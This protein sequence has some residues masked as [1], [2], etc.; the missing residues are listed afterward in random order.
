MN[1]LG[2]RIRQLRKEKGITQE[3][4]GKLFNL[5]KSTISQYESGKSNPDYDTLVKI[6]K[7]FNCS[8][9]YLLG[10]SDYRTPLPPNA[11]PVGKTKSIPILGV[12]RAGEPIYADENIIGY[13]DVPV[14][15]VKNGEYFFLIV[16]G[17]SMIGSRIYPG[18]KV[19][20]RRQ[21]YVENND[22]AVVIVNGDEATL[23]RV[24]YIEEAIIL[25]P[26]NP[27]YDPMIFKAEEVRIIGKVKK[28]VFEV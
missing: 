20:V 12:I 27:K 11:I 10:K 4:L 6:S 3:E 13:E 16:K 8:I 19:L 23:K 2:R 18:D 14:N 26:D 9:D 28:V 21:D 25:Y 1:N 7:Y 24:K 17:D 22:I 15:D 5:R